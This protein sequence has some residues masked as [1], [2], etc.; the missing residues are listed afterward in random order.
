MVTSSPSFNQLNEL[1]LN[2]ESSFGAGIFADIP[3]MVSNLSWHL[4]L[5]YANHG[6]SFHN[7]ID[8]K[9]IDLTV[10][11]STLKTPLMLRYVYP[12]NKF[13]PFVNAGA[14]LSFNVKNESHLFETTFSENTI[15]IND[16]SNKKLITDFQQGIAAGLGVEYELNYKHSLFFEIRYNYFPESGNS[17]TL[18]NSDIQFIT[19]VNF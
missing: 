14:V 8:N 19:S 17:K 5:Q 1:N 11:I 10:N 15:V 4:E 18:H 13:I 16:L 3:I 12:F 2:A 6:F 7:T 9:D